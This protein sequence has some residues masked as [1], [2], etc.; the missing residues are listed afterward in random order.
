MHELEKAEYKCRVTEDMTIYP[1]TKVK[2]IVT[3]ES[4]LSDTPE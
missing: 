2:L 4:K 1:F 3:I